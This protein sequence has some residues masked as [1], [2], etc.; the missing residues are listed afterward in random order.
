MAALSVPVVEDNGDG[1]GPLN[2]PEKLKDVP[3]APYGKNDKLGKAAD[4]TQQN[5][6]RNFGEFEDNNGIVHCVEV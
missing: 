4:W 5:Y 1:W 2:P 6:Q 3:Y